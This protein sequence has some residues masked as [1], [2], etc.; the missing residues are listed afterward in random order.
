MSEP[1]TSRPCRNCGRELP[2]CLRGPSTRHCSESC[3]LSFRNARNRERLKQQR[4]D[5][6]C[7]FKAYARD[8]YAAH[9]EDIIRRQLEYQRANPERH[10][11]RCRKY[12]TLHPDSVKKSNAA[13]LKNNESL[14]RLKAK[15][16]RRIGRSAAACP[17]IGVCVWCGSPF[18]TRFVS[19]RKKRFCSKVCAW[20]MYW[21][22]NPDK[23]KDRS[24]RHSVRLRFGGNL[25]D[26]QLLE[27]LELLRDYKI[28]I[29]A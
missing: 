20:S 10:R 29:S 13:Y 18:W 4:L 24:W 2:S 22:M 21:Q 7:R 8:N 14:V 12:R 15:E 3:R 9:R 16:R 1:Q 28:R 17:A 26:G 19:K 6:P 23:R 25:P 5:D 11:Q 27:M